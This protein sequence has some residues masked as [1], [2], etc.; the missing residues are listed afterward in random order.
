M[1]T[2]IQYIDSIANVVLSLTV[3]ATM[4]VRI[5]ALQKY[6]DEV[7]GFARMLLKICA[8][9]PTFG[10]NPYTKRLNEYYKQHEAH[11]EQMNK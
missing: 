6:A 1:T 3:L 2:V 11:K 8:R 10:V 5:P 9:L 7:D 4:L